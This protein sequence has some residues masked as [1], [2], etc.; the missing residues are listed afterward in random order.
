MGVFESSL[1]EFAEYEDI[2]KSL[3]TSQ[4]VAISGCIEPCKEHFISQ[5][6]KGKKKLLITYDET[7]ARQM[8]NQLKYYEQSAVFYPAKDIIFYNADVHGSF[9]VKERISAIKTLIE[10]KDAT[11]VTTID[12]LCDN[13]LP[14]KTIKEAIID[15]DY[16][17]T[18]DIQDFSEKLVY[19]GYERTTQVEVPGQFA[20]RGSIIDI[21]PFTTEVPVRIDLWDDEIDSIKS[22]DVESQRSIE[23]LDY[24]RIYPAKELIIRDK[25]DGIEAIKAE[26]EEFYEVLM[27]EKN[28]EAAFRVEKQVKELIERIENEDVTVSYE[29]Y[30]KYF[31]KDTVSFLSYF[32]KDSIIILDEPSRLK[33]KINVVELEFRESMMHR[34]EKGYI[35]PLQSDAIFG[36]SQIIAMLEKHTCLAVQVLDNKDEIVPIDKKFLIQAKNINAYNNS[37]ELLVKDIKVYKKN[38]Y[39]IVIVSNSNT[40]AKR[41]A[42]DLMENEVVAFYDEKGNKDIQK[43]EVMVSY[44]NLFRGFEYPLVK[45]VVIAESDIFGREKKVKKSKKY[46]GKAIADFNEL[47]IGDYVVHENHGIGIYKGIEKIDVEKVT[48][49]YI[50]IEYAAGG[51]LYILATQLDVIQKYASSEAKKPKINKLGDAAWVKVKTK[52][53]GAVNE[54]AKELVELYAT[55]QK[56]SGYSFSPDTPWQKEFEELF[57]YDE[58][59]DQLDAIVAT[60]E[61]MESKKV[62][63]RLICGDVGFGKTEIAIRAAFKAVTDGKQVAYLVPTTILAQQ[64]YNTFVQRMKDFAV[65]VDL[66]SRFA[67]PK[68]IKGTLEGLKKGYVD[69]VVGTHRILSKDV[70]FKDLGLLIVDEEQRFGVTHKEKI[71]QLKKDVDVLTL[72][73]TPIP[74]TLHMSLSGIRDMS[75][76]EEAPVDR[77]P[78]QTFVTEYNEEMVRE[79]ISRELSRGGQVYYVYNRVNTIEDITRK[80]SE[81]VPDANVTYAHGQMEERKLEKIMYDFINGEIDVLVSTTIIETGLDIPNVNTIIIHDADRFGLSQLYQLRGR[82]G[83]SNR[84]AYAFLMYKQ[85]RLLRETAEKRL[86]AIREFTELGSGFKIAMKDLEIR[87]AG[88]VLG[89][90][91]SGHMAAVGYDLYCKMLNEAVED[92]KGIKSIR[93]FETNIDIEVDAYIPSSYIKSEAQ[94]LDVYKRI[95]S[96]DNEEEFNDMV[97]ELT[98][99]FGDVPKSAITLLKVSLLKSMAHNAYIME[100][101]G[102]KKE[103]RYK[104]F[105]K[106]DIDGAKIPALLK[107]YGRKLRIVTEKN[108]TFYYTFDKNEV[109]DVTAYL[110]KIK[111]F[112]LEIEELK[113][114]ETD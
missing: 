50:K 49:D 113:N 104:M 96:I 26:K 55:R 33:E 30:I 40:R 102:N 84:T 95:A 7:R 11:V 93:G 109:P 99:R 114:K 105:E 44:G 27:K 37:F 82:V 35:M 73:A 94:K 69:I 41:L 22:F 87:G 15:I 12:A 78:I 112:I 19:L 66:M 1:K 56:I 61:D 38:G 71:K 90:K 25:Y 103:V 29:S 85:D 54:V 45:F 42:K 48:K 98:D 72:S 23:N 110:E 76:L 36:K 8:C 16:S 57:P 32:E 75:V 52:T 80:I 67:T 20:I 101:A 58:T 24:L 10:E 17:V 63:D 59:K 89:E 77:M 64:H 6:T 51:K 46:T 28:V 97:D 43:G 108:P 2:K 92:L 70:E 47:S 81:L 74:R 18:I 9:I 65:R 4:N 13:I 60:K 86:H 14:L 79:A 31:S 62:M 111:S 34:L 91:Q 39:R 5:L 88:N 100:I 83:R 68:S 3:E 106:A 107:K 21:Y 53:Q